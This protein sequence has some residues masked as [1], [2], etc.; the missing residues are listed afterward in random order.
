MFFE[1]VLLLNKNG[2]YGWFWHICVICQA[3][4]IL[5]GYSKK[6]NEPYFSALHI[7]QGFISCFG[8]GIVC[9]L[10]LSKLPFTC[11][12]DLRILYWFLVYIFI[13]FIPS[14]YISMINLPFLSTLREL[15]RANHVAYIT[16]L[17][18]KELPQ[19]DFNSFNIIGTLILAGFSASGAGFILN[20]FHNNLKNG[21]PRVYKEGIAGGL[22]Y[23]LTGEK[24]YTVIL[25][26]LLSLQRHYQN[27]NNRTNKVKAT[28]TS[29]TTN[30][31]KN[32]NEKKKKKK[33]KKKTN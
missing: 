16:S 22:L 26:V 6:K 14:V 8:S 30:H 4:S 10:L 1:E 11:L 9:Q 29:I 31:D 19:S 24:I 18:M 32:N 20:G 23:L 25:V 13:Y 12:A 21:L 3:I 5:H 28:N 15:C 33:K 17:A 7:Y 27:E 2:I